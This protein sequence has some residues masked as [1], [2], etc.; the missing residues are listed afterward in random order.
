MADPITIS[1]DTVKLDSRLMKLARTLGDLNPMLEELGM[2]GERIVK[3]NFKA[4]GRPD[5]WK[6]S[7]TRQRDA[8]AGKA[9]ESKGLPSRGQRTLVD[10]GNLQS[11]VG[12]QVTGREVAVGSN[13]IY[14]PV[15]HFGGTIQPKRGKFLRFATASGWVMTPSV[16]MP[17][18]P[19]LVFP[20]G[21]DR[22][23]NAVIRSKV[24]A[25]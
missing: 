8:K 19:W 1:F 21:S 20:P 2:V 9:R 13:V 16:T 5:K 22:K 3:Q 17:A 24:E 15:H 12:Y 7:Q 14:G 10:T 6:P 18:R 4:G 25:P 23:F 11:S